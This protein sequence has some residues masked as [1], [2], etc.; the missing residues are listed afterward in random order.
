MKTVSWKIQKY[1]ASAEDAYREMSSLEKLTP[2]NLVDL[3]RDEKSVLHSDFE[4][5]DTIAG[6]KYRN[7][8]ASE[9]IRLLVIETEDA[10]IEPIRVFQKVEE[11]HVYEPTKMIVQQEDKYQSLLKQAKADLEV[12]RKRYHSLVELQ[13]IFEQIDKL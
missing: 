4:W 2:Q 12:F 3:A 5:N 9:M 8:Q 6:E 1:K 10:N 7:I 13:E 11:T